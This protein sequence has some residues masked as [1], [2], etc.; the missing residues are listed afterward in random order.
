MV[1][2]DCG[3]GGIGGDRAGESNGETG[4]TTVTEQQ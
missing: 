1:G 2:V 4:R 3:S